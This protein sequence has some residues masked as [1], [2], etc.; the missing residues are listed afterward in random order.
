[1]QDFLKILAEESDDS[2]LKLP[3]IPIPGQDSIANEEHMTAHNAANS[4]PVTKED[5]KRT[6]S[7]PKT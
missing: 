4:S 2:P 3:P 6:K 7:S 5:R 1:M